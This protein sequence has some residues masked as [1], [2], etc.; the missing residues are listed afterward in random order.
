MAATIVVQLQINL[1][2][3]KQYIVYSYVKKYVTSL[4]VC[5]ASFYIVWFIH[6]INTIGRK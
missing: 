3:K 2:S 1:K 4:D 5:L 6:Y